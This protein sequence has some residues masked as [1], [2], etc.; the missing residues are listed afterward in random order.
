LSLNNRFQDWLIAIFETIESHN[1]RSAKLLIAT[2]GIIA[3]ISMW[4]FHLHYP[5]YL[6]N[7]HGAFSELAIVIVFAPPYVTVYCLAQLFFP[8]IRTSEKGKPGILTIHLQR[9]A[10]SRRWKMLIGAGIVS[11]V[12][13]LLMIMLSTP[14]QK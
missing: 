12:N 11:A 6:F 1:G 7:S 3:T 13:L 4:A 10:A 9:E 8:E 14:Q 2:L 5:T